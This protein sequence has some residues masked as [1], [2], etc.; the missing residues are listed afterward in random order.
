MVSHSMI[1]MPDD[2]LPLFLGV[3]RY[4]RLEV[5]LSNEIVGGVGRSILG[6]ADILK[7]GHAKIHGKASKMM[8]E[9]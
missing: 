2:L 7:G 1:P 9:A 4:S 6:L 5:R 8:T 3:S